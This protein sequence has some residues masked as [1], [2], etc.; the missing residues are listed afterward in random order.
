M[1]AETTESNNVA[2]PGGKK[3]GILKH[4]RFRMNRGTTDNAAI[5]KPESVRNESP[6]TLEEGADSPTPFDNVNDVETPQKNTSQMRAVRFPVKG[7]FKNATS[8]SRRELTKP[9]PAREAAFSGPPR[10][11]WIDIVSCFHILACLSIDVFRWRSF[12]SP[13]QTS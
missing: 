11:D 6:T 2:N 4:F 5:S 9:P 7:A 10:Y 8:R 3:K 12:P 1:A 13:S